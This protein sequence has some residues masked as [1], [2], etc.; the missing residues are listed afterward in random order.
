MKNPTLTISL[1]RTNI[2]GLLDL[3]ILFFWG[4]VLGFFCYTKPNKAILRKIR[5]CISQTRLYNLAVASF[6]SLV[7]KAILLP[8]EVTLKASQI[9]D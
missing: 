3:G 5:R 8:Y 6:I 9:K 4:L 2:K 1:L 7:E